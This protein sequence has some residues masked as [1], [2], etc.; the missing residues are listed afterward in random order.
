MSSKVTNESLFSKE[1]E[2]SFLKFEGN[3]GAK[4]LR[5]KV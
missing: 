3:Y 2:K 1:K 4:G 5:W